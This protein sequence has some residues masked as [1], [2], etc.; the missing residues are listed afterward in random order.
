MR[1]RP[2]CGSTPSSPGTSTSTSPSCPTRRL[3]APPV[4]PAHRPR[5]DGRGHRALA[6]ALGTRRPRLLDG[7]AAVGPG[8]SADRL[9]P[10]SVVGTGGCAVR[11]GTAG[12]PD[13]AAV[14]LVYADRPLPADL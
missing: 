4:G 6:R 3:G 8:R 5:Q 7:T 2:A 10:G 13:P 12:N 9:T 11:V 14:R 1:R